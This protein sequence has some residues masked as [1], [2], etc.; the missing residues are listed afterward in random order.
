MY[1]A[2]ITQSHIAYDAIGNDRP[3]VVVIEFLSHEIPGPHQAHE[4][5]EQLDSLIRPDLPR[6]YVIDFANV[7]GLGSTAFAEIADFVRRAGRVRVC[8]LDHILRLGASLI[9]L[10]DWVEYADSRQRAIR[11]AMRDWM[12]GEED[13]VD[14][15]ASVSV[16]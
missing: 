11:A 1:T 6:N 8:N 4:L 7:R 12:R 10:D 3:E 16:S 2:P 14:Y 9:G 15:P 5:A 13:T